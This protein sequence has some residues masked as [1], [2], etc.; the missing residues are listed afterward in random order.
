MPGILKDENVLTLFITPP[1]SVDPR[2]AT[3]R[4]AF[5]PRDF[6]NKILFLA[7][8][9]ILCRQLVGPRRRPTAHN[10]LLDNDSIQLHST[11]KE[12]TRTHPPEGNWV[13]ILPIFGKLFLETVKAIWEM[14]MY[15]LIY[16]G[17]GENF[18][19]TQKRFGLFLETA[20]CEG[21]QLSTRVRTAHTT[22][23]PA[24]LQKRSLS[25]KK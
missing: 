7:K 21:K 9:S 25:R 22:F 20:I 2:K 23:P 16:Y 4:P 8:K 19:I 13:A 10:T 12:G 5:P 15:E 14:E 24:R 6:K 3:P 11:S 1:R 17:N 18:G